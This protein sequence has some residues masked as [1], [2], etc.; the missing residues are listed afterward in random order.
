MKGTS[1]LGGSHD[2]TQSSTVARMKCF[3]LSHMAWYASTDAIRESCTCEPPRC[4][5]SERGNE[6]EDEDDGVGGDD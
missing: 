3:E 2:S 4:L 1:I 5:E 6:D